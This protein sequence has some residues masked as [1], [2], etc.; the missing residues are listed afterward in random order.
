MFSLWANNRGPTHA[1][2][3]SFSVATGAEQERELGT[4]LRLAPDACNGSIVPREFASRIRAT[5]ETRN[6]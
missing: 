6:L 2:H 4:V 5:R 3:G 1:R